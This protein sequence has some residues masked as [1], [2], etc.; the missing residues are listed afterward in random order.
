MVEEHT[1]S[2]EQDPVEP[3]GPQ[4]QP[5]PEP[6][7]EPVAYVPGSRRSAT[8]TRHGLARAR[9][10]RPRRQPWMWPRLTMAGAIVLVFLLLGVWPWIQGRLHAA[11]QLR[12]AEAM[13]VPARQTVVRI[14]NTVNTQLSAEAE[15]SVP[16]VVTEILVARRELT[17]AIK[18]IDEAM[19]H[20]TTQ[21]RARA[22]AMRVA[23]SARLAMI[24]V[25]PSILIASVNAVQAKELGDRAWRLTKEATRREDQAARAYESKVAARVEGASVTMGTTIL[26]LAEARRLY[27]QAASAFPDAGFERYV[28]YVDLRSGRAKLMQNAALRWLANESDMGRTAYSL[29]RSGGQKASSA[30]AALPPAPGNA[31]GAGFR[32]VAGTAA[33]TYERERKRA[34]E[35]DKL[36][37]GT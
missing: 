33:D 2:S 20:L 4:D 27:S 28:A 34:N 21:E 14:D 19:P 9:S 22:E 36:L 29:Y 30:L 12:Q 8:T 11:E 24:K 17:T 10:E 26:Q 18:L 1:S 7:P 25:A 13:L 6:V 23:A 37:G 35:A 5:A 3:R 16:S 15:P 31:T 32:K